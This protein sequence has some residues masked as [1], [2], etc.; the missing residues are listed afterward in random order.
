M[1][2]CSGKDDKM[3]GRKFLG[4]VLLV[5]GVL[6]LAYG[7]FTYTKDTDDVNIG[8]V[9][10]ELKEKERV[11]VPVWAGAGAAIAGGVLLALGD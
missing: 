3:K 2:A 4:L 1:T 11:N 5:L 9:H 6:S 10:V 8:P 7:G